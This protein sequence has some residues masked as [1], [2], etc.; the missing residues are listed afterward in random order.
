MISFYNCVYLVLTTRN[1]LLPSFKSALFFSY[2]NYATH[3]SVYMI[4]CMIFFYGK[5]SG[6]LK[7]KSLFLKNQVNSTS[8]SV[9]TLSKDELKSL[10]IKLCNLLKQKNS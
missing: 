5:H 8:F 10:K 9:L 3:V 4:L 1:G 7:N 6:D 2:A